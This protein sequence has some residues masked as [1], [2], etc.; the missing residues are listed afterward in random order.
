MHAGCGCGF[1]REIL[2]GLQ[3]DGA[4]LLP[5]VCE[6][7]RQFLAAYY[8]N[9]K[10]PSCGKRP[11]FFGEMAHK[12]QSFVLYDETKHV[13]AKKGRDRPKA[14]LEATLAAPMAYDPYW[15]P[16]CG[17]KRLKFMYDGFWE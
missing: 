7:C 3:A 5:A 10:C 11:V 13:P 16:E 17:Q 8:R 14:Y 2:S 4:Y 9:P 12:Y 1:E 6:E 15:C